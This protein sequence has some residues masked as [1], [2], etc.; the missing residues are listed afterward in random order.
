MGSKTKTVQPILHLT[1]GMD[2]ELAKQLT[3]SQSQYKLT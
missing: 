2:T 3:W 1:L